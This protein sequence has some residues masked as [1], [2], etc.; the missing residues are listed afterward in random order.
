MK[1]DVILVLDCGATNVRAMAVDRQGNIIARAATANAS[2]IAAEKSDWH[3]WSLEAIM[4][5]FADCCRQIHDQLASCTVRGI[6][7]TT[8]G[9][10]GALVDEQ[11]AL[12]YPIISWKCP[13][14]AA[15]ME[16]ISQYM[17]ARQLQRI[18]GVGAFAF[19]TL[20]KLVWLKE[21]HPQLLAQVTPANYR[22]RIERLFLFHLQAFDWNCPQHI[23]PRYSAQQ[24]AEYSQNLQQR[25]HDLEQENQRLQQQLARRGE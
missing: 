17:P 22:A 11:G 10:D 25:I 24:V 13:R 1:Q 12:L 19:N 8:F 23:T 4:Q 9:V 15:V 16:K 6:T 5:R 3:Q 21:D 20:Y 7:V 18:A 2:D 14:T